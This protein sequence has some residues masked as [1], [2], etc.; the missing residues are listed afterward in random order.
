MASAAA[1]AGSVAAATSNDDG[2]CLRV[3]ALM[4]GI[5]HS[6]SS[7]YL[8]VAATLPGRPHPSCARV[9]IIGLCTTGHSGAWRCVLQQLCVA[10]ACVSAAEPFSRLS[11]CIRIFCGFLSSIHP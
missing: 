2:A 6:P 1:Q 4:T 10:H 11:E 8:T 3:R 9:H 7:Q 5:R